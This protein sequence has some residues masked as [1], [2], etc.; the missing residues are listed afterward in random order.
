MEATS[1]PTVIKTTRT[2]LQTVAYI[3]KH[4]SHKPF[5]NQPEFLLAETGAVLES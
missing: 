1:L 5:A 4:H 3:L 2:H